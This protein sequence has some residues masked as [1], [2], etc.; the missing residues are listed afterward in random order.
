ME[1]HSTKDW[2]FKVETNN[3][4][5]VETTNKFEVETTMEVFSPSD[6]KLKVETTERKSDK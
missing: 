3:K 2:I 6:W 5:E 1:S 4:F